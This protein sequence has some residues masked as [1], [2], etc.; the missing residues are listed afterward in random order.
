MLLFPTLYVALP[1]PPTSLS[2]LRIA[3]AGVWHNLV[4]LGVA[5]VLS[6]EGLGVG[7]YLLTPVYSQSTQ[8]VTVVSV[9][10]ASPLAPYLSPGDRIVKLDDLN[11]A[12]SP[13]STWESYLNSDA[14]PSPSEN[15][16]WCLP[17]ASY[18]STS[19]LSFD[20]CCPSSDL[21]SPN[22]CFV[23]HAD[24]K[25]WQ[26]CFDPLP[27]WP[28]STNIP[29]RCV[30]SIGCGDPGSVCSRAAAE[31]QIL[32][33]ELAVGSEKG[34]RVVVYQGGSKGVFAQGLSDASNAPIFRRAF[35]IG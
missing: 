30:N 32:R 2:E 1:S 21:S 15:L 10:N 34:G 7:G 9:S 23:A 3:T 18:T 13:L 29:S 28:P 22:I 17:L 31:E 25:P 14:E 6:V 20:D 35:L 11:L 4:M 5:W 24:N 16:G 19:S 26:G 33:I 12:G 27:F 8:S